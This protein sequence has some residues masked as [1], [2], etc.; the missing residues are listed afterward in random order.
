MGS[1]G[2]GPFRSLVL[3]SVSRAV[4]QHSPVPVITVHVDLPARAA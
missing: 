4:H 3:G 2:R 1:R